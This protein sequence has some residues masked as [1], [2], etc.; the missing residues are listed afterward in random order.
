[1]A[2]FSLNLWL[3]FI[4]ALGTIRHGLSNTHDT[5]NAGVQSV[6]VVGSLGRGVYAVA[7]LV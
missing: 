4:D 6:L 5:L 2:V 7:P 1:M 3:N